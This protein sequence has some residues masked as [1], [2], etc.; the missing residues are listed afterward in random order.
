MSETTCV[1]NMKSLANALLFLFKFGRKFYWKYE[2]GSALCSRLGNSRRLYR[3]PIKRRIN[4]SF[5]SIF[6][7]LPFKFKSV[8]LALTGKY[9]GSNAFDSKTFLK[10]PQSLSSFIAFLYI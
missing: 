6:H 8:L 4:C 10:D 1:K 7:N 5:E 3:C 9:V 2:M